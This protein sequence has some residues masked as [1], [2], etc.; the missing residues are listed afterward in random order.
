MVKRDARGRFVVGPGSKDGRPGPRKPEM[1]AKAWRKA[2]EKDGGELDTVEQTILDRLQALMVKAYAST[3]ST[4]DEFRLIRMLQEFKRTRKAV[5]K[6]TVL[7][8]WQAKKAAE[9]QGA[10]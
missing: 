2:I 10:A 6:G 1:K 9:Q 3:L 4:D 7:E 5:K 8:R